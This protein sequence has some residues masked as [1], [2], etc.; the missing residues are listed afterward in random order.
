[1][2]KREWFGN[3]STRVSQAVEHQSIRDYPL[4]KI[5]DQAESV[6]PNASNLS[7]ACVLCSHNCGLEV[8]VVDNKIEAVRADKSNPITT[9]Y[10]C[11]K[12]YSIKHYV[13]H[14]QRLEHPLKRNE[15]GDYDQISW[16][17]AISEIA[18]KLSAIRNTA[19]PKSIALNGIG[20]QSNH[21]DSFYATSFMGAVGTPWFFNSYAQEKSQ[22][23]WVD[24]QMSNTPPGYFFHP[25]AWNSDVVLVMG[26]N[27]L[28]SN[29]GHNPTDGFKAL[30]KD[31]NKKLFVID[32][33]R[34]ET[35]RRADTHLAVKPGTDAY[36]LLAMIKHILDNALHAQKFIEEKVIGLAPLKKTLTDISV[37]R[38]CELCDLDQDEVKLVAESFA[39][40]DKASIFFD[41]GV[42]QIRNSTL[43]SWLIKV[44]S[45]V[46]GN[47]AKTGG[48]LFI[49][50]F[51]PEAPAADIKLHRAPVSGIEAISTLAPIG[52]FSPYLLP[53]EIEAG[54]I[55]ALIVEG[56]NPLLS[57]ADTNRFE[58]ALKQLDLLVVI[59]PAFTETARIADY[60]LPT[61][62]GYE[63]WEWCAFPKDYPEIHAQLRPPI[64]SGPTEALPEAEIYSRLVTAMGLIPEAPKYLHKLATRK[65][66]GLFFGALLTTSLVKGGMDPNR[67]LARTMF[68]AYQTIGAKLENPSLSGI[69]II[70]YLYAMLNRKDILR[71]F[72]S[73]SEYKFRFASP[74]KIGE[75]LFTLIMQH[76]EGVQLALKDASTNFSEA[77]KSKNGKI[78]LV[79]EVMLPLLDDALNHIEEINTEFPYTLNAGERTQWNSNTIHRSNDWRKGK[80]PHFWIKMNAKLASEIGVVENDTVIVETAVGKLDAPVVISDTMPDKLVSIPNGF[81][82]KYPDAET[83]ELKTIGRNPNL[84][85]S[86]DVRDPITACPH[87]KQQPCKLYK[88][89]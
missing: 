81:G 82:M 13:E 58:K 39:K 59:E 14:K 27:P 10:T 50:G 33:R 88:V 79:P 21:M 20:G 30:A 17:Q 35:A 77:V 34:S 38:M 60:V 63:K 45:V 7:T 25:D 16:D 47:Y 68:T 87:L 44:L 26:T 53:E 37:E 22:H 49:S 43:V 52:M 15:Q 6:S 80:G 12:A 55:T 72:G 61:P 76:P 36:L 62:T 2:A 78:N 70:S 8:D 75:A 64:L 9:G 32:P 40:A 46:T 67:I 85:T 48:N 23:H 66:K 5:Q 29:R 24:K 11:N 41:L 4:L 18:E 3:N 69:W 42:E 84:V 86:L 28:I 89:A 19:G 51:A 73:R 31:D 57:Y 71:Y 65:N 1:M 54:N 56:S 74:F 83:G